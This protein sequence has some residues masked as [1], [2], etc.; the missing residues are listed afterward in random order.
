MG[1]GGGGRARAGRVPGHTLAGSLWAPLRPQPGPPAFQDSV[2]TAGQEPGR[3]VRRAVWGHSRHGNPGRI[4]KVDAH[5]LCSSLG[6]ENVGRDTEGPCQ[7]PS[8]TPQAC[9]T[10]WGSGR[11]GQRLCLHGSAVWGTSPRSRDRRQGVS[12]SP[13]ESPSW[14]QWLRGGLGHPQGPAT[15]LGSSHCASVSSP[16]RGR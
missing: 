9:S 1:T 5:P 2:S 10:P 15:T 13:R 16:V 3:R 7:R 6:S 4:L 14:L 8:V 12:T 11:L